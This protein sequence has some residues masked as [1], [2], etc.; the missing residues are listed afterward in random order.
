MESQ[1]TNI[2][3]FYC[4]AREETEVVQLSLFSSPYFQPQPLPPFSLSTPHLPLFFTLPLWSITAHIWFW[5]KA[6][7]VSCGMEGFY[8][9]MAPLPL[10]FH[11]AVGSMQYVYELVSLS[12]YWFYSVLIFITGE[13]HNHPQLMASGSGNAG[14][15]SPRLYFGALLSVSSRWLCISR[16][17]VHP[18]E[19]MLLAAH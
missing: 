13:P 19:L 3:F 17:C 18:G 16:N 15:W 1:E 5:V 11:S 7:L 6:R 9:S 12:S 4:L 10:Q 2:L 8:F 14:W